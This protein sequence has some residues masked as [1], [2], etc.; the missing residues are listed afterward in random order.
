MT[1]CRGRGRV[2]RGMKT[3]RCIIIAPA[4]SP[5][6]GDN[7]VL[8]VLRDGKFSVAQQRGMPAQDP[9]SPSRS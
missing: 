7:G 5:L 6:V 9:T 2:V 1:P 3:S 4:I 8:G